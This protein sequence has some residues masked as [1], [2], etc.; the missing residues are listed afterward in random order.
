M[1][2]A[3][4][5]QRRGEKGVRL[6]LPAATSCVWCQEVLTLLITNPHAQIRTMFSPSLSLLNQR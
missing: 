3:A 2:A 4:V 5:E 1:V 6:V